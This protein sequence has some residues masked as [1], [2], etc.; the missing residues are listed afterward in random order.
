MAKKWF[1]FLKKDT[2]MDR[3]YQRSFLI[4]DVILKMFVSAR[5]SLRHREDSEVDVDIFSKDAEVNRFEREVRRDVFNHLAV[6]GTPRLSSGLILVSIIIDI[7]RIGDYMKNIVELAMNHPGKLHGAKFEDDLKKV[8]AAVED[9]I[10][11]TMSCFQYCDQESAMKLLDQYEW[12]NPLCD[13]CLMGLIKEKE[14]NIRL[15][16]AVSLALYFRWLKRIN[17]HLR[18][19]LTSVVNPFDRIGF[20]PKNE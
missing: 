5:D 13:E 3:A 10:S 16:D 14:M 11:R 9:S 12:V 2:L 7:E 19:I 15:G 8:E 18:N 6:S 4:F 17:S 1:A 20:R